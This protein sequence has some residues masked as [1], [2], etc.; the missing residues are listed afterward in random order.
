[1][2]PVELSVAADDLRLEIKPA[3]DRARA[4]GFRVVDIGAADGPLSPGELS[5]SGRRHFLRHLGDLGLSL[6]SLR[7]PV[8][9]PGYANGAAGERRLEVAKGV[10][11]LAGEMKVPVVSTTLGGFE[12]GDASSQSNRL[13]E[14]LE[15][16]ANAADQYGVT[17]AIENAG[18]PSADLVA[19][20]KRINCPRLAACCDSGAM[21]MQGEDP[22]RAADTMAGK[23]RL[24]RARDAVR[25]SAGATGYETAI[26]GGQL[27]PVHFLAGL[28]E[29]G[30][31][32]P[33]VISRSTGVNPAADI[34]H[35]KRVF[36]AILKPAGF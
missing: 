29:A 1:M 32:G 17:V 20:L 10:I 4:L 8:S 34:A 12:S 5:T 27:D 9:G 15:T 28:T 16:L 26:G 22:H 19:L 36:D 14:A 7:G 2:F 3:L 6:K 21:L 31:Q 13:Q 33:L 24:V 11:S 23:I 18:V 35:A 30:Y 25:G